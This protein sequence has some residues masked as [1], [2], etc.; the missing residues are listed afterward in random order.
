MHLKHPYIEI[1]T[2]LDSVLFLANWGQILNEL[3]VPQHADFDIAQKFGTYSEYYV[4]SGLNKSEHETI[5]NSVSN[6]IYIRLRT[7]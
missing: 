2:Y 1:I 7:K 5:Y 6:F 4:P 3:K